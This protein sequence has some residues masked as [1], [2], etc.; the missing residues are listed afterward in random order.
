MG[1]GSTLAKF[2]IYANNGGEPGERLASSDE[3]TV[4]N[5]LEENV[6]FTFSGANRIN[7]TAGTPYW[8]GPA[9]ADPGDSS[10][11][12]SR[13]TTASGRR[14]ASAYAPSPFGTPT[15]LSGPLDAFVTY[16]L[17]APPPAVDATD[18][19]FFDFF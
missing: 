1:F 9:W 11:N 13:G 16:L 3:R 5:T 7:V 10:I 17:P 15:V 12:Y 19:A 4:A 14:E 8:I 2:C 6:V 18:G